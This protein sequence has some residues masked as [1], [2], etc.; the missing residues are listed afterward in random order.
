MYRLHRFRLVQIRTSVVEQTYQVNCNSSFRLVQIRTS[1]V[2][3]K[4]INQILTCFRPVQIRTSVVELDKYRE[5]NC[6]F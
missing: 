3:A 4:F 6:K 2:E 5:E 1:V